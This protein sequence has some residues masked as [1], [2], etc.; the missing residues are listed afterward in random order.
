[1]R[2]NLSDT[3]IKDLMFSQPG[4]WRG[5]AATDAELAEKEPED[6]KEYEWLTQRRNRHETLADNPNARNQLRDW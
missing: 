6:S 2:K 4:F 5:C 1:M 3:T